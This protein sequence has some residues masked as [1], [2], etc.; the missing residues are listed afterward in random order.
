MGDAEDHRRKAVQRDASRPT[1]GKDTTVTRDKTHVSLNLS[2][3]RRG[4]PM[5]SGLDSDQGRYGERSEHRS[6]PESHEGCGDPRGRGTVTERSPHSEQ[7]QYIFIR[8]VFLPTIIHPSA[9]ETSDYGTQSFGTVVLQFCP[10]ARLGSLT[11]G[12]FAAKSEYTFATIS[13]QYRNFVSYSRGTSARRTS[14]TPSAFFQ[15]TCVG[16]AISGVG[17]TVTR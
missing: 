17:L 15:D 8:S 14:K 16:F 12:S 13:F 2:C 3:C 6:Q 7:C 11:S 10:V 9:R 4:H 5:S 1:S